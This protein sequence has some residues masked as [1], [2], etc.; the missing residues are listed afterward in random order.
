[1]AKIKKKK[2]HFLIIIFDKLSNHKLKKKIYQR[3]KCDICNE[4]DEIHFRVKSINH[5][6]WIFCCKKCWNSFKKKIMI[7]MEVPES[8]NKKNKRGYKRNN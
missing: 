7:L 4:S 3:Q 5:T 8:H 1:M 6:K 2:K